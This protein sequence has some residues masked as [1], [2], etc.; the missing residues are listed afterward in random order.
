MLLAH[1]ETGIRLH[2][3][4]SACGLSA[5]QFARSF[6]LSFGCSVHRY[7]MMLRIRQA[8]DLMEHSK[9][10]L[11]EIAVETGFSD[12]PG[13]CRTFAMLTGTSPGRWRRERHVPTRQ[14]SVLPLPDWMDDESA[15]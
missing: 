8:K 11:A 9:L 15:R 6:K 1:L 5:S 10:S 4:S 14:I 7:F 3:L 2:T 12:Q 13:F